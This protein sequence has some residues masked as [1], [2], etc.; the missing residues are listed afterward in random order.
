MQ[1]IVQLADLWWNSITSGQNM[2]TFI[3]D[4]WTNTMP[5]Q[6]LDTKHH[7]PPLATSRPFPC[8]LVPK[9]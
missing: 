4:I 3:L 9:M 5:D 7:E 6:S 2:N 1:K 8:F